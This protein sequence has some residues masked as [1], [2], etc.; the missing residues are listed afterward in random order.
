[1]VRGNVPRLQG[2]RWEGEVKLNMKNLIFVIRGRDG[3]QL[4][5]LLMCEIVKSS[6]ITRDVF[7]SKYT[8]TEF[9]FL[10]SLSYSLPYFTFSVPIFMVAHLQG[11]RRGLYGLVEEVE[12]D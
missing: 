3:T 6:L 2:L 10:L 11:V 1:M 12:S 5:S 7:G 8:F 9:F 4:K